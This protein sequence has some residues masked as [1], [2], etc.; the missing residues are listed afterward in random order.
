M[1]I[2]EKIKQRLLR[3][4]NVVNKQKREKVRIKMSFS[5]AAERLELGTFQSLGLNFIHRR[6]LS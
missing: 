4:D 3:K 6:L 5:F 1:H 2:H